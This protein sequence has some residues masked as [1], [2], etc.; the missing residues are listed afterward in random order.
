MLNYLCSQQKYDME[1]KKPGT[2]KHRMYYLSLRSSRTCRIIYDDRNQ[3]RHFMCC[4]NGME[5][6]MREISGEGKWLR[7]LLHKFLSKLMKLYNYDQ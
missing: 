4:G 3:S 7:C 5:K 2:K 6:D 1:K